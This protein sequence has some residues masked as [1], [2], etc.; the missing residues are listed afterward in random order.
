MLLNVTVWPF[1]VTICGAPSGSLVGPTVGVENRN[2]MMECPASTTPLPVY[3]TVTATSV[4]A[5]A[6]GFAA[7]GVGSAGAGVAG[8]AW[9]WSDDTVP[10][11]TSND[12]PSVPIRMKYLP[13]FDVGSRRRVASRH[14]MRICSDGILG[15]WHPA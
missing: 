6:A 9:A 15:I 2:T 7:A 13:P 5:I 11:R 1:F 10:N 8:R 12:R 4:A 3:V 14:S